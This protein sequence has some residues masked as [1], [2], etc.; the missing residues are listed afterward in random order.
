MPHSPAEGEG[1]LENSTA[2]FVQPSDTAWAL[3]H[4]FATTSSGV[5]TSWQAT[6]VSSAPVHRAKKGTNVSKTVHLN[7]QSHQRPLI[8]LK[9]SWMFSSTL[10]S[11]SLTSTGSG[12]R[13]GSRRPANF[14][15]LILWFW[16]TTCKMTWR[17]LF[18]F[19]ST[20][21]HRNGWSAVELR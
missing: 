9:R 20:G 8:C 21:S 2:S 4:S 13:A 11:L 19:C 5:S 10:S 6:G 7:D 3:W 17:H 18:I 15:Q 12:E 1:G 16:Q 14:P